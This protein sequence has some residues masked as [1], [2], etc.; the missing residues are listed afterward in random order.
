[1]IKIKF[2]VPVGLV[3]C[4]IARKRAVDVSVQEPSREVRRLALERLSGPGPSLSS[5]RSSDPGHSPLGTATD[6]V[7]RG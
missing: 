6:K 3:A 5:L 7:G 4:R 2:N 1:M